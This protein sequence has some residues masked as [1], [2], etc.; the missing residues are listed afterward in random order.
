MNRCDNLD[1]VPLTSNGNQT[2]MSKFVKSSRLDV[3][4]NSERNV[5]SISII[6]FI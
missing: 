6:Y 2:L 3:G 1:L 4:S 5:D